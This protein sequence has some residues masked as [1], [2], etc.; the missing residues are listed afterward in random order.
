MRNR[1]LYW[2][3]VVLTLALFIPTMYWWRQIAEWSVENYGWVAVAVIGVV[4]MTIMEVWHR[5]EQRNN[6]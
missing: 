6:D 1:A 3:W 5:Y 2:V 4:S